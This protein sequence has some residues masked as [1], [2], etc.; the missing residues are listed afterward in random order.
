MIKVNILKFQKVQFV[1]PTIVTVTPPMAEPYQLDVTNY[2][3]I[4]E[5]KRLFRPPQALNERK[6]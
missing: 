5:M 2:E 4:R 3:L 6:K 1:E